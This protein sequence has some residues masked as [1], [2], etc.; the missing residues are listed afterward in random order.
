M[1]IKKFQGKTKE[2]AQKLINTFLRMISKE[3]TEEEIE[4]IICTLLDEW[5]KNG[6]KS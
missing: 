4:S 3:A 5:Q 1:I 6:G 2:E